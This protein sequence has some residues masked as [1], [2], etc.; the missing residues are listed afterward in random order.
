[1]KLQA[2]Q[3]ILDMWQAA[4]EYSYTK[5]NTWNWGGRRAQNCISDA[6]Q[7]LVFLYP[8]TTISSLSIESIEDE[9]TDVIR[10]LRRLGGGRAIPQVI[11][12]GTKDYLLR[13]RD[14]EGNPTFVGGSYFQAPGEETEAVVRQRRLDV[15]D[16]YSMSVTLCLAVLGFVRTYWPKSQR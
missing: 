14:D 1:M 3:S 4:S 12:R 7:L 11:M 6:E 10:A 16:A 5:E 9:Q 8:A 13:Y 15:V 2:R